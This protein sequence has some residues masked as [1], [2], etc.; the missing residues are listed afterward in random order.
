MNNIVYIEQ[1]KYKLVIKISRYIGE[2]KVVGRTTFTN[3]IYCRDRL[4]R[5]KMM[6]DVL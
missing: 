1:L 2:C 3:K 4:Y 5:H 6:V